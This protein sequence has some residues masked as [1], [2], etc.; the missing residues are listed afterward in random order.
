MRW[1]LHCGG[2]CAAS[3]EMTAFVAG[4]RRTGNGKGKS[5]R[6]K[7]VRSHISKSRYGAPE[8]L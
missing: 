6:G 5:W 4:V 2:K 8:L 7:G 1:S 3:V